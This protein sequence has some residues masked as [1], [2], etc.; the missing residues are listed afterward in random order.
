M[1]ELLEYCLVVMV[2]A[3]FVAGSVATYDSFSA[4]SAGLQFNAGSAAIATLASE[5]ISNGNATGEV[6]VPATN[7]TCA[8]GLL[9][10]ASGGMSV[11]HGVSG[12]CSF[13]MA[14]P[15]GTHTFE[16]SAKGRQLSLAVT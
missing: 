11:T 8:E 14:V 15:S 4:F 10:L 5:A 3:I 1:A 2:S 6:T 16:F 12:A 13:S 7:I 9:T